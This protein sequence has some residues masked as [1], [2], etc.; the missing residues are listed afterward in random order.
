MI[1][2]LVPSDHQHR[3]GRYGRPGFTHA[4]FRHDLARR[5]PFHRREQ[6]ERFVMGQQGLDFGCD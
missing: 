1:A 6:H 4:R 5:F 3:C 2:I